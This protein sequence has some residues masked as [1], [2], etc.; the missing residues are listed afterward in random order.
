MAGISSKALNFGDPENKYKYNKGSE[1]QNKEF[2][3]GSGLETY[4]TQFRMFDPQLGRWWQIDPKIENMEAW[5]PYS[6]MFDNPIS[7]N[8]PLGDE[9]DGDPKYKNITAGGAPKGVAWNNTKRETTTEGQQS[10]T[11]VTL[12]STGNNSYQRSTTSV[13]L[14]TGGTKFE[15]ATGGPKEVGSVREV[16]VNMTD[17]VSNDGK[18]LTSTLTVT[19]TSVN[20]SSNGEEVTSAKSESVTTVNT[21][22]IGVGG[23]LSLTNQSSKTE[24]SNSP[25]LSP[26]LTNRVE[27]ALLMNQ[28]NNSGN[29]AAHGERTQQIYEQSQ[30]SIEH[31]I[32]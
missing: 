30:Q 16:N 13:K 26:A 32:Q 21:Y 10:L 17:K 31:A 8:D 5:S 25:D 3:D 27:R 4:T 24:T 29:N 6:S 22:S 18:T 1:L 20:I 23:S 15:K 28:I 7:K 12:K 2:S 19:K 9:P 14:N 11:R